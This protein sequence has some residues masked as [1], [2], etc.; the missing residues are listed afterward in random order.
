[1]SYAPAMRQDTVG[2][3]QSITARFEDVAGRAADA[4]AVSGRGMR[5]TYDVLNRSA[6]RLARQIL[7]CG[8][9]PEDRV[10]F[11]VAR[12]PEQ[13]IVMLAILKAGCAYVP[14]DP[15]YPE[16]RTSFMLDDSACPLVIS[17]GTELP[18]SVTAGR[19]HL[20]LDLRTG[21]DL[22]ADDSNLSQVEP[23]SLAYVIYTSGSTGR[24]KGVLI[25]HRGVVLLADSL[26]Q[27]Y[28]D[29]HVRRHYQFFSL[30]FDASVWEVFFSLL[31]GLELVVDSN[32]P[33]VLEPDELLDMLD[34]AGVDCF[35]TT[36]SYLARAT[37][38]PR[39]NLRTITVCGEAC[40]PSL[41]AGWSRHC[42]FVNAYGP[43]ENTVAATMAEVDGSDERMSIGWPLPHVEVL[44][45]EGG[46][47]VA[48]GE[49]GQLHLAGPA[50]A[51]G[52]QRRPELDAAAFVPDPRPGA[53]NARMYRTGDLGVR[54]DDGQFEY[55]G[56]VDDQVKIRGFRVEP[57]EIEARLRELERVADAVVVAFGG[58]ASKSL[59]GFIRATGELDMDVV[60][61]E[62]Q[63]RLPAYMV[64]L[65]L[66]EVDEFPALPS[67]KIN[68]R[69]LSERAEA[70][71]GDRVAA[72]EAGDSGSVVADLWKEALG[73]ESVADADDFFALG[74]Q[75]VLAS[76]V[77]GRTRERL[78]IE[79]PLR[80]IFEN[81]TLG[82]YRTAVDR[83]RAKGPRT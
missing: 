4:V 61:R 60:R 41:A 23:S 73:R 67:G 6:N 78:G 70:A 82:A 3:A 62:L 79:L 53:G 10:G 76:Q 63:A 71:Y 72:G 29:Y 45:L 13:V 17:A 80:T 65:V 26:A 5:L 15:A 18:E 75:S 44:V 57:S 25:E 8:V 9:R 39:P 48:D 55:L 12:G 58:Q 36:P 81:S 22:P 83:A 33:A 68:R 46:R 24:P 69:A 77:V 40:P 27:F 52:Y 19:S 74:G 21:G 64:P 56:R 35:M 66:D 31:N 49:V 14:L 37:P 34:A 51:R 2:T 59:A 30:T 11:Q 54:R 47:P 38:R 1:V 43:T 42:R 50:V 32:G 16:E 28:A 20:N 7:S